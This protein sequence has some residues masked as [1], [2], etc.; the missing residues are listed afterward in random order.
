MNK[1]KT[2]IWNIIP[3]N[4]RSD[5]P[6][7]LYVIKVIL[8]FWV[9][10]FASELAGEGIVL[11]LHFACGKNPLQGEMFDS[12]TIALISYFGYGFM[13]GIIFLLWK[14]FQKKT[15][16]E[17]GFTKPAWSYFVG[18][19][20]GAVLVV[21][22]VALTVLT[23]AIRFNGVFDNINTGMVLLMLGGFVFQGAFEEMLCRGVVQQLLQKKSVP[24]AVGV[25]AALFT[26]SHVL[27]MDF[28]SPAIAVTAVINLLL[29][30]LIFS[31]LTIRFRSIWAACGMHS[32]WNYILYSILGL[33]LSGSDEITA[34]VFNMSSVGKNIL[35][36]GVYGIEASILT[37]AV[38]VVA[39]TLLILF[40]ARKSKRA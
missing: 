7:I 27:N 17:L 24:V 39:A 9:F 30:S 33:N 19:T 14:L 21:I 22:S 15:P 5:M 12:N 11:A 16:A 20:A 31:L 2:F 3:F 8:I 32:I 28:S 35:N 26:I 4:N 25:S 6:L 29:I 23:G 38:L 37:T 36:G 34:S 18:A 13:I 10:K 40:T 1:I